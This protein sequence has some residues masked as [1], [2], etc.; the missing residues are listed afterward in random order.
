MYIPELHGEFED[1][2]PTGTLCGMTLGKDGN[3]TAWCALQDEAA[4]PS[5]K[6]N[7]DDRKDI[8]TAEAETSDFAGYNL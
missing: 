6:G 4:S 3:G 7:W 2:C 5:L 1:V 8:E